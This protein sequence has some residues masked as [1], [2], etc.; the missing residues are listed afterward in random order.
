MTASLVFMLLFA[1]ASSALG[2]GEQPSGKAKLFPVEEIS[3]PTHERVGASLAA[4]LYAPLH[5]SRNQR[6][7]I[8]DALSDEADTV[9]ERAQDEYQARKRRARKLRYVLGDVNFRIF[10]HKFAIAAAVREFLT[11]LQ[12]ERLDKMIYDG[13]LNPQPCPVQNCAP[14]KE[15]PASPGGKDAAAS[16]GQEQ[17]EEQENAPDSSSYGAYP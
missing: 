3:L 12:R 4:E 13:Y 7:R 5:F 17:G 9:I 11:P 15:V 6:K 1:A 2:A 16:G 10:Q 8:E 14:V